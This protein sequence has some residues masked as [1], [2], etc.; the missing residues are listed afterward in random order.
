MTNQPSATAAAI[1]VTQ[2]TPAAAA[3][4][5]KVL[6]QAIRV[7]WGKFTDQELDD[8]KSNDDLVTQLGAKYGLAKD[9][10]QRD[11]DA[12]RNGRNI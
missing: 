6:L 7:K 5:K 11:A 3:H 12:M 1:P 9:V 8:L 10:A 4:A 2:T